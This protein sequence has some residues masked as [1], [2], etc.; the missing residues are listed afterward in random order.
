MSANLILS[1]ESV[2][3]RI[4][5][6]RGKKVMLDS[7]LAELYDTQTRVLVQAV[8]RNTERFPDDFMFQLNEKEFE[9]LIS[10]TVT[11][12]WGGNRKPPYAFTEQ[13]VAMLSGILNSPR[14]VETNIAIMRTFVALRKWMKSNKALATKIRQ[15]E[16][17]YDKQFNVVFEAIRQL[18]KEEKEIRPIG[19]QITPSKR[20]P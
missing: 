6:I 9:N 16:S 3:N 5:L 1:D 14:A 7:D 4:Y 17:K 10:Q 13:G 15:L 2:V 20:D 18:L 8:S 19:F 11:S 12:S